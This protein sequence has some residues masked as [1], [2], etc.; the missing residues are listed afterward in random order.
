MHDFH[1]IDLGEGS[2]LVFVQGDITRQDTD[3]IVNAA[4]STLMG[5]GGVDGAIHRAG[6]PAILEECKKI[7]AQHGHLPPGEAVSTT[8]GRLTAAFVIHTV[9]PIWRGGLHGEPGLLAS[10]YRNSLRLADRLGLHSVAFPAISTGAYGYPAAPA[11]LL[12]IESVLD[13]LAESRNTREVRF[14]LFDSASL[15]GFLDAARAV[16]HRRK[17][18]WRIDHITGITG[19]KE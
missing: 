15:D 10:A 8:G 7:V 2:T 3:A 4:N 19:I 16:A 17:A 14:V 1:K 11:A 5:G 9:G 18:N 13:A 12:A 6:G